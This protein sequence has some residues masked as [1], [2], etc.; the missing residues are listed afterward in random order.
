MYK[1]YM[2]NLVHPENRLSLEGELHS[3]LHLTRI[4]HTLS[5]EPVKV[6]ES[7]RRERI[8]VVGVVE[9]IEHLDHRNNREAFVKVEW[10]LKT[11]VEREILIVFARR[12]SI[13]CCANSRCDRLSTSCLH[14]EVSFKSP[15]QFNKGKEV[16]LVT[17]VAVR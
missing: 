15:T 2:I 9:G 3:Q 1:I 5:Q 4:A 17:D 14:P 11:P 13:R 16:E 7:W 10:P 6:E 12:V 8:D